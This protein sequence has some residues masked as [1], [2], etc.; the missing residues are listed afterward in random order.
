[1]AK[2]GWGEFV[3]I[4]VIALLVLGPEKLPQAG[5][6]L[7]KAVRSVKKYI[8][9]ATRELEDMGDLKDIQS[10]VEGIRKD[11][12]TM[13]ANLEKTVAE[14]AAKMEEEIKQ[15]AE[16]IESAVEKG[17]EPPAVTAAAPEQSTTQEEI[18]T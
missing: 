7:G 13:G 14:D 16:D 6:A 2:I 5:R 3:I 10:D 4:L 12:R 15:T 8:H 17:P 11:L 9:E 18:E 1:M